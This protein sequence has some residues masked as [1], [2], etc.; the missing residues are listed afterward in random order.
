MLGLQYYSY[1][2]YSYQDLQQ[3]KEIL[4]YDSIGEIEFYEDEKVIEYKINRKNCILLSD[5]IELIKIGFI[6][7]H[8]GQLLQLFINLLEKV[9]VMHLKKIEHLYLSLD[10]IWL[11]LENNQYL[12]ILYKPIK[13][14]IAFTGYKNIFHENLPKQECADSENIHNIISNIINTFKTENIFCNKN[15]SSKNEIINKIYNVIL[16]SCQKQNLQ[17]TINTIYQLLKNNQFN[18]IQQT[19]QF[20]DKLKYY[21]KRQHQ[22]GKIKDKLQF[23]ITKY[24]KNP[25]LLDLFLFEKISEMRQNLK[26]WQSRDFNEIQ[27]Q[28]QYQTL[29]QNYEQKQ[30][31]LQEV[32]SENINTLIVGYQKVKFEPYFKFQMEQSLIKNTI[33]QIMKSKIFKYFE[34]SKQI[35]NSNTKDF[36][37]YLVINTAIPII[38]DLID[39]FIRLQFLML[40]NDLI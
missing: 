23:L 17:E 26:N 5:L 6:R 12:T 9:K 16:K 13:Y 33:E 11:K 19:I 29:L 35:Y 32:A 14:D 2:Y 22:Q 21:S 27:E 40:I 25:L 15:G 20:D 18:H 30:Q 39:D 28:K 31:Q 10:R 38:N 8:L 34:N 4:A 24:D 37:N 1:Q 3:L 7:F 36:Q